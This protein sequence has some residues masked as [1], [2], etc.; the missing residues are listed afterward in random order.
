MTP[1]WPWLITSPGAPGRG[2][3]ENHIL[4]RSVWDRGAE[5]RPSGSQ[6]TS[7]SPA[8]DEIDFLEPSTWA[9]AVLARR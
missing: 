6:S 3:W 2:P 4:L 1:H 9:A 5:T 8:E 7:I